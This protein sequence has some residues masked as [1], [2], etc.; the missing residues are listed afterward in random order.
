MFFNIFRT[1]PAGVLAKEYPITSFDIGLRGG[2]QSDLSPIAFAVNAVGFEPDPAAYEQVKSCQEKLWRSVSVFRG[3]VSGKSGVRTLFVPKDP[4]SA[5]LLR[6]DQ[7]IGLKFD[8][9]QFFQVHNLQHIKA[10]QQMQFE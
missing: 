5:S 6:H 3:G 2:F 8:K 9:P 10:L 4:Q 1:L 7:T